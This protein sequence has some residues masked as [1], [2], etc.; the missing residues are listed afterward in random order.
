MRKEFTI[1]GDVVNVASRIEAQNKPLGTHILVSDDVWVEAGL[2]L[3]VS[4]MPI[5][6][7]QL[8]GRRERVTLFRLA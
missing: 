4:G 2:E 3:E 1:I 7:V 8:S 6:D 5:E